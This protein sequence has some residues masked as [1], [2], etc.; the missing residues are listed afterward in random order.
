[1]L[2]GTIV[3]TPELVDRLLDAL[4]PASPSSTPPPGDPAWLQ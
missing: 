3:D 1:V 2:L 4:T